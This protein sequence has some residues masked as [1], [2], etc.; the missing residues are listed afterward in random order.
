MGVAVA[1]WNP[2]KFAAMEVYTPEFLKGIVA[3][4]AYGNADAGLPDYTQIPD[5]FKPPVLV[6]HLYY[7]KISLAILLGLSAL[8][9][10]ALLHTSRDPPY[11][12]LLI[13]PVVAQIVSFLG[14]AVRE[15][16]RKPWTIYGIM[17]VQTAHTIN[18]PSQAEVV[19][20]SIYLIAVLV[21][22]IFAV[23]RFLWRD[24]S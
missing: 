7:T 11:L 3:F 2:E 14:W 18:P 24:E 23:Y 9:I 5:E 21:V 12:F 22:L 15:I 16:G 1:E 8:I 20:I 10:V 13:F 19:G 4:L 17:D 6:H